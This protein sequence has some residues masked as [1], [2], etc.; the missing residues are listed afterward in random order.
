VRV[1][2]IV[3]SALVCAG[4]IA[5]CSSNSK[6]SPPSVSGG[7]GGGLGGVPSGITASGTARQTVPADLAF[8]VVGLSGDSNSGLNQTFISGGNGSPVPVPT[9]NPSA[10]NADHKAIRTAV[11]ALGLPKDAVEFSAAS[12][13]FG[14]GESVVEVEVPVAKLPKIAHDVVDAIGKAGA[15]IS[16]QG[17]RLSVRDCATALTSARTK[18]LANARASAQ[19][20]ADAGGVSLGQLVSVSEASQSASSVLSYFGGTNPCGRGEIPDLSGP[21]PRL[22][23]LDAPARVDLTESVAAT[24]A[25]RGTSTRTLGAIGQGEKTGPADAADI[26]VVPDNSGGVDPSGN[27]TTT[28]HIDKAAVVRALRPFGV[29]AKDVEVDNPPSISLESSISGSAYIRV[30][31]T[32]AQL[33]KSGHQ[34]NRGDSVRRARS[35]RQREWPGYRR[36]AVQHIELSRSPEAGSCRSSRGRAPANRQACV[37][38]ARPRRRRHRALGVERSAVL[39]GGRSV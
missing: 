16:G 32:V 37:S 20:L 11:T 22:V 27:P 3:G 30:H 7:T 15:T 18:A 38:S 8:V 13:S 39:S 4:L 2:G 26:I 25:L 21:T 28:T 17:L 35:G 9:E 12:S 1:R 34:I 23:A 33:E 19:S 10:K 29:A 36:R 24:F 31:V 6:T 5:G 14:N